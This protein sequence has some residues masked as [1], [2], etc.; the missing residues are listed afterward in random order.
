MTPTWGGTCKHGPFIGLGIAWYLAPQDHALALELYEAVRDT[1]GWT[2]GGG[3]GGVSLMP[4]GLMLN[5]LGLVLAQEFGDMAGT[6]RREERR[7]S[8]VFVCVCVCWVWCVWERGPRCGK[9]ERGKTN[10]TVCA[11]CC[12]LCAVCCVLCVVEERPCI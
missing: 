3:E 10:A 5:V 9:Q 6:Q 11:V 2:G 12:V 1:L 8:P 7:G 4:G